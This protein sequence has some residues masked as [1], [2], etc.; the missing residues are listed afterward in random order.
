MFGFKSKVS[1]EK[2]QR[3]KAGSV[4]MPLTFLLAQAHRN[5]HRFSWNDLGPPCNIFNVTAWRADASAAF[6]AALIPTLPL[7]SSQEIDQPELDDSADASKRRNM[8]TAPRIPVFATPSL[9]SLRGPRGFTSKSPLS[10]NV[11]R[12][13]YMSV[14]VKVCDVNRGVCFWVW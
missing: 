13:S 1:Q 11:Y 5:P 14:K 6:E 3:R 2:P 10:F 4:S 8:S 9:R 7:T 12:L